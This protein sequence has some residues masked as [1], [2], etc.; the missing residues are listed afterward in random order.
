M[1]DETNKNA[2]EQLKAWAQRRREEAGPPFELHPV[3][4][5]QLQDEVA[6]TFPGK[7]VASGA[8]PREGGG[9]FWPRLALVGSI[10]GVLVA[11]VAVFL[12]ASSRTKSSA[13]RLALVRLQEK[14]AGHES[15]RRDLPTD[16]ELRKR[17]VADEIVNER[18]RAEAD[19]KA[20][21]AAAPAPGTPVLVENRPLAPAV[22]FQAGAKDERPEA[23]QQP[24]KSGARQQSESINQLADADKSKAATPPE[25]VVS[26]G[27]AFELEKERAPVSGRE[28]YARYGLAQARSSVVTSRI[29][30]LAANQKVS[31]SPASAPA[32]GQA[33]AFDRLATGGVSGYDTGGAPAQAGQRFAQVRRLR[34]NFNSPPTP[35]VLQSFRVEQIDRQIRVVDGDGSVYEGAIEP[36]PS[37]EA[38]KKALVARAPAAVLENRL[39]AKQ[40]ASISGMTEGS[41]LASQRIFFRV[42][43]TN[44]TL[45][46]SVVFLGNYLATT[47]LQ[48]AVDLGALLNAN[49]T[50]AGPGQNGSLQNQSQLA[51][52]LIQGQATIGGSN[53]IEINAAPVTP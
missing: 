19:A 36:S 28:G 51:N 44:I 50:A 12:P 30:A 15:L 31:P 42:A 11:I 9:M 6:R 45:E 18:G 47:N 10:C 37:E 35:N 53:R 39:G 48:N 23:P 20:A 8:R 32:V 38:T 25:G 16:V 21:S 7:P 22:P 13:Q 5:K 27:R 41:K 40:D 34:A 17:G 33:L 52:A 46:Q 49:S 26:G 3:S 24:V 14:S 43:G 29:E 4:R 1:P 2:E